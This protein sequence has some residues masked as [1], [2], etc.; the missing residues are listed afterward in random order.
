[1]Q[2][3]LVAKTVGILEK[4]VIN[5]PTSIHIILQLYTV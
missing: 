4:E 2:L 1:M 5:C 3:I